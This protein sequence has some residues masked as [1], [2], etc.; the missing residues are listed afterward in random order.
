MAVPVLQEQRDLIQS[1]VEDKTANKQ[2]LKKVLRALEHFT[3]PETVATTASAPLL[4][5]NVV[6]QRN[7]SST[8]DGQGSESRSMTQTKDEDTLNLP[9]EIRY[10]KEEVD[11]QCALVVKLL[12]EVSGIQ[13]PFRRYGQDG[14]QS[15]ET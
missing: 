8:I 2:R 3:A 11:H 12:H 9:P 7:A 4:V 6:F 10:R 1:R 5:Q 13:Y 14:E 15:C